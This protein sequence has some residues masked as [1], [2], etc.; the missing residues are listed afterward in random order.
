MNVLHRLNRSRLVLLL[1]QWGQGADGPVS[2]AQPDVAQQL[3]QWLGPLDADRLNAALRA[4][5]SYPTQPAGTQPSVKPGAVP[6]GQPVDVDA[7][8]RAVQAVQAELTALVAATVVE[9]LDGTDP[10]AD[11]ALLNQRYLGV[12]KALSS[13]LGAL[14]AQVRQQL[15]RGAPNLRRLAALDGV[16]EQMLAARE[17]RLWAGVPAHLAARVTACSGGADAANAPEHDPVHDLRTLLQAELQLR[18][19]PIWGLLEAAQQP[20]LEQRRA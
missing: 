16:M 6:P 3:S 14:R 20:N 12:Q 19:Q 13:R 9:G 2:A 5:E 17:Q 4:I 10:P 8:A 18:L 7:L 15:G 1:Q 11:Q